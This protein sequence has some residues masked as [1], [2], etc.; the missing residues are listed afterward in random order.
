MRRSSRTRSASVFEAVPHGVRF[1]REESF[2]GEG[3]RLRYWT[4][5]RV[6]RENRT[7]DPVMVLVHGFRG[8]HHGLALIAEALAERWDV[9]VPDL[10]GFGRS[11]EFR[12]MPHT[13]ES[14]SRALGDLLTVWGDRPIVLVGHSFGSVVAA[15]TA[16]AGHSSLVGLALI[17]PIC[18]PALESSA[19]IPSL[20]ASSFYRL[21]ANLP[22]T[23]GNALVRSSLVTRIS[24]EIM[25]KNDDPALR[26]FINGQHDAYFGSFVSR[27]VVL[28]AYESSIRDTVRDWAAEVSVPTL[29]VVAA[30]DDLG[31]VPGQRRLSQRF[32]DARLEVIPEV[33]H[34]IHYEAPRRAAAMIDGFADELEMS[35]VT[36]PVSVRPEEGIR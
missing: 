15:R 11:E 25:M 3:F 34:L 31:S 32:R 33:G 2:Q 14:Y 12:D 23:W 13:A 4:Y 17:N 5:P 36:P 6:Q 27:R 16:A 8:D 35:A 28:E 20:A 22:E 24:S 18:E 1:P 30:E 26:R 29:L 21:C 10:P 7:F 9:V 19:R